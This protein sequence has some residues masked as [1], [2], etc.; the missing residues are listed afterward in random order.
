MGSRSGRVTWDGM[1]IADD[2]PTGTVIAV[3]RRQ[4]AQLE[5]LV[6]HRA[7]RG[8]EYEGDWAWGAP[9]GCRQPGEAVEACARREL[10]EETGLGLTPALLMD[11]EEWPLFLVEAPAGAEV[12]LSAEHDAYRWV[13]LTA[14][15]D[16]IRPAAVA[17]QLRRAA[18]LV[19]AG[20]SSIAW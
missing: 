9:S 14:A 1:A 2:P 6:L 18:E 7:H 13:Q 4:G 3:V 12:R 20:Q 17:E 8:R 16:L 5:W 10:D 15:I 11:H 19:V